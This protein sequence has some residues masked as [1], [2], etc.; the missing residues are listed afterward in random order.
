MGGRCCFS[1]RLV[2]A[3]SP[4]W[5]AG[6]PSVD[7]ATTRRIPPH[8]LLKD[9]AD[10]HLRCSVVLIGFHHTVQIPWMLVD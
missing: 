9:I 5:K 8:W 7:A 1:G 4:S 2:G 6:R 10:H 3:L